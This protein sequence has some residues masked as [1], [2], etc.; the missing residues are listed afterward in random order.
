MK[1]SK[2]YG[3]FGGIWRPTDGREKKYLFFALKF[4]QLKNLPY[5]CTHNPADVGGALKHNENET[6]KIRSRKD[7]PK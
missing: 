7:L 5:I 4:G 2:K 6:A 3:C 1:R